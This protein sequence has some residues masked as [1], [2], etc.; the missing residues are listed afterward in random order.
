[1]ITDKPTRKRPLGRPRHR[2]DEKVRMNF[3]E[4]GANTNWMDSFREGI[5]RDPLWM[6]HWTS[7]F[8]KP[9]DTLLVGYINFLRRHKL[10]NG[11][12]ILQYYVVLSV[13]E[14]VGDHCSEVCLLQS[15]DL[16]RLSQ[17]QA[18]DLLLKVRIRRLLL[19]SLI[20]WKCPS[21]SI[22]F[23]YSFIHSSVCVNN[24]SRVYIFIFT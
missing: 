22:M 14:K 16:Y 9:W 10:T 15:W 19:R 17:S 18:H 13:R 8:H 11:K 21:M 12:S 20:F 2:W 7:A 1:M 5:I 3:K 6:R 4:I 24:W 23:D